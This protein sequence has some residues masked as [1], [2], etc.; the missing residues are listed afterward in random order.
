MKRKLLN[1]ALLFI[2]CSFVMFGLQSD[3][4]AQKRPTRGRPERHRTAHSH[5]PKNS[6]R[7]EVHKHPYYY[8]HGVFY[9]QGPH[10]FVIVRA[11]V[12]ARIGAL[13][14]GYINLNIGGIPY[15]Y[16]YGT[17]YRYL[18]D[19][20]VYVVVENPER[21]TAE[22]NLMD[23]LYLVDGTTLEGIYLGGTEDIVEFETGGLKQDIPITEIVSISFAP[24]EN[25]N[26]VD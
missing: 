14:F 6:V 2:I 11:P 7:M 23:I 16:F 1:Q 24:T 4:N 8:H 9:R 5:L 13:P 25:E 22:E 19:E 21:G 20:Q 12:G 26:D 18:P 10:G 15:F 17:Y 3:I